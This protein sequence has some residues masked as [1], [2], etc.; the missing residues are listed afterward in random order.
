M[1]FARVCTVAALMFA[2]LTAAPARAAYTFTNIVDSTTIPQFQILGYE[3]DGA[4]VAIQW[5]NEIFTV[6]G[7]VSTSIA[8]VGSAAPVGTFDSNAFSTSPSSIGLNGQRVSFAATY[9]EGVGIFSGLGGPLT[10][11]AKTGMATPEGPLTVVSTNTGTSVSNGNVVFQG[12]YAGN[13][14]GLFMGS[15]GALTTIANY[16]D[17]IPSGLITGLGE[18][19][20]YGNRVAFTAG[21]NNGAGIYTGTGGALTTIVERGDPVPGSNL[22][23]AS[24]F[25]FDRPAISGD[26]VAFR[27]HLG[28]TDVGI[29][30]GDGGP[31]T[32]IARTGDAAPIG[33][34]IDLGK[35]PRTD[36]G[37]DGN[38]VAFLGTFAGGS[39]QGVFVGDG[40]PLTTVIK[41]GDAMFGS[42]V[43]SFWTT[44][45]G[46]D[47]D[48]SGRVVFGY[49]LANNLTGV[50]MAT[51]VPEP[52][53]LTLAAAMLALV[54]RRRRAL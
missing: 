22:I 44:R 25:G 16:G 53:A 33:A 46:L 35:G 10:L 21:S 8:K 29:F 48:G 6:T 42:T 24:L 9:A 23:F 20:I 54:V 47:P 2:A 12:S 14:R 28:G 30:T 41:K 31:L 36:I 5:R 4:S 34:F 3:I 32:T 43:T 50:A 1:P 7:G 19:A 38:A 39:A 18:P 45:V 13:Q 52:P 27:A 40:G 37:F 51:P 49:N 15:G 26:Q 17:A 11:I